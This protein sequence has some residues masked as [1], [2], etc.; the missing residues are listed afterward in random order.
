VAAVVVIAPLLSAGVEM[1][2]INA[3]RRAAERVEAPTGTN[4]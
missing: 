1:K 3:V 4:R 2:T